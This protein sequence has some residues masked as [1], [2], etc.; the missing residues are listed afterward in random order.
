MGLPAEEDDELVA[1]A[2]APH[3]RKHALL[4]TLDDAEVRQAET[5]VVDHRLDQPV[6][7]VAR[8]DAVDLCVQPVGEAGDVGEV[9]QTGFGDVGRHRERVLGPREVRALDHLNGSRVPIGRDVGFHRR[10][11]IAEK[12]VDVAVGEARIRHRDREQLRPRRVAERL[13][14][15]RGRRRGGGDVRPADIGEDRRTACLGRLRQSGGGGQGD[16][17]RGGECGKA[18][19]HRV[20]SPG[21]RPCRRRRAA[22]PEPGL[23]SARNGRAD[24]HG[25]KLID[26]TIK[27]RQARSVNP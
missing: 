8:L 11:P 18:E 19:R 3:L 26:R 27:I 2:G 5:A 15:D 12:D 4:R 14:H 21:S 6:A 17:A 13:Q 9:R 23:E 10:H 7:V 20:D 22:P 24:G 16:E 1:L 25:P